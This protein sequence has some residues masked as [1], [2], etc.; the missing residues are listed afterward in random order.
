MI[1]LALE[2]LDRICFARI[3]GSDVETTEG[4]DVAVVSLRHLPWHT[5][6]G[7]DKPTTETAPVVAS[8][9]EC[10]GAMRNVCLNIEAA[11]VRL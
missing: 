6:D 7:P 3:A 2:R 10:H 1:G 9:L 4:I 11:L 5:Y 8:E